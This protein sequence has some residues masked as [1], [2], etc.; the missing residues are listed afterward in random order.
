MTGPPPDRHC[1]AEDATGSQRIPGRDLRAIGERFLLG[2]ACIPARPLPGGMTLHRPARLLGPSFLI[3][4]MGELPQWFPGVDEV[5][6]TTA[7]APRRQPRL[8][9]SSSRNAASELGPPVSTEPRLSQGWGRI[10][11]RIWGRPGF[12][13]LPEETPHTE[14]PSQEVQMRPPTG[15]ETQAAP[16]QALALHPAL[17]EPHL[18][19]QAPPGH[20]EEKGAPLSQLLW[21]PASQRSGGGGVAVWSR[22]ERPRAPGVHLAV[23]GWLR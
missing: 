22:S 19:A 16:P 10:G 15:R 3:C 23:F 2:I 17:Q 12:L 13:S 11:R 20:Q 1:F 14:P 4:Q 6:Q 18:G 8:P 7:S 9:S 5:A 21:L